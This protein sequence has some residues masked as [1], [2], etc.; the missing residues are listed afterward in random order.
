MNDKHDNVLILIEELKKIRTLGRIF[1]DYGPID[2]LR[3]A[4]SR[5]FNHDVNKYFE[6][7][8][9]VLDAAIV[10]YNTTTYRLNIDRYTLGELY[11]VTKLNS[12]SWDGNDFFIKFFE[13]LN[14]IV[15]EIIKA[16]I[17]ELVDN[18][19]SLE[20]VNS[21]RG[22]TNLDYNS[23]HYTHLQNV[24]TGYYITIAN[25]PFN[26]INIFSYL[27]RFRLNTNFISSTV[28]QLET[29]VL[30]YIKLK[31]SVAP[32]TAFSIFKQ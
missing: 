7:Y 24:I 5:L 9:E 13:G 3:L 12:E 22:L 27:K 25:K 19:I 29:D 18:D 23:Q 26:I 2:T 6:N 28:L 1:V 15:L 16:G 8:L 4:I 10:Y 30:D 20:N 17:D 21:L 14:L 11:N 31:Y 32:K